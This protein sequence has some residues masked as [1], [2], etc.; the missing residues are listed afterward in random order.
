MRLL[1]SHA[2]AEVIH[3]DFDESGETWDFT[4]KKSVMIGWT[5]AEE[6]NFEFMLDGF[7]FATRS[8]GSAC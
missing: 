5:G 8:E 6:G 3:G 4:H 2:E 1:S 7:K